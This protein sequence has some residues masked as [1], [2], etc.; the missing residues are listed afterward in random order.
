MQA[1]DLI[2]SSKIMQELCEPPKIKRE[3]LG[4]NDFASLWADISR[5]MAAKFHWEQY[6]PMHRVKRP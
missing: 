3:A 6:G 4:A 1:G 5:E 2:S